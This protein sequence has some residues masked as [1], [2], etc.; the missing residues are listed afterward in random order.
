MPSR[1]RTPSDHH[2]MASALKALYTIMYTLELLD[3]N[4]QLFLPPH[5]DHMFN[6]EYALEAS[7]S[8][9]AVDAIQQMPYILKTRVEFLPSTDTLC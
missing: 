5:P 7:F 2:E 9:E 3:E 6:A 8:Q 1:T 4:D